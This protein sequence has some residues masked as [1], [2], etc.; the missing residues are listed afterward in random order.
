MSDPLATEEAQVTYRSVAENGL[1]REEDPD[2]FGAGGPV[3]FGWTRA[4]MEEG[5]FAAARLI[6][7]MAAADAALV[8]LDTF[9]AH[10]FT[11]G[12]SLDA[13]CGGPAHA[14]SLGKRCEG[15]NCCL[16]DWSMKCS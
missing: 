15:Q 8:W 12:A 14:W 16:H 7:A 3:G 4:G 5:A 9:D 10:A 1:E 2:D 13:V 6:A 11:E